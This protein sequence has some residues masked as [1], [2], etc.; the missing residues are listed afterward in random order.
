MLPGTTTL[1]EHD[2]VVDDDVEGVQC[3]P[4]I[5]EYAMIAYCIR[6]GKTNAISNANI[7]LSYALFRQ[8][9]IQTKTGGR[10]FIAAPA[11]T[12]NR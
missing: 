6:A 5:W 1:F 4:K 12:I 10:F 7:A 3:A 8:N 11:L 9:A 2:M